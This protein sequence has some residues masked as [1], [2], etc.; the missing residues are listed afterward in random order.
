MVAKVLPQREHMR[1]DAVFD[2]SKIPILEKLF[3]NDASMVCPMEQYLGLVIGRFTR[4]G[5]SSVGNSYGFGG[6]DS[7]LACIC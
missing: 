2:V 4:F 7:L 5:V 1:L 6:R 3:P